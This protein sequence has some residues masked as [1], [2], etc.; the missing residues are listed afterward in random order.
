M[1]VDMLAIPDATSGLSTSSRATSSSLAGGSFAE[2]L[3][4]STNRANTGNRSPLDFR[5]EASPDAKAAV[6]TASTTNSVLKTAVAAGSVTSLV[7][8]SAKPD[9]KTQGGSANTNSHAGTTNSS[10]L[11]DERADEKA[12]ATVFPFHVQPI[13]LQPVR[14]PSIRSDVTAPQIASTLASLIVKAVPP[15]A[16][17]GSVRGATPSSSNSNLSA[18]DPTETDGTAPSSPSLIGGA[19]AAPSPANSVALPRISSASLL[20]N[21]VPA[22]GQRLIPDTFGSSAPASA[23]TSESANL[24]VNP[25]NAASYFRSNSVTAHSSESDGLSRASTISELAAASAQTSAYS[26]DNLSPDFSLTPASGDAVNPANAENAGDTDDSRSVSASESW[27]SEFQAEG[28]SEIPSLPPDLASPAAGLP[29]AT[30]SSAAA[31]VA[32]AQSTTS[33]V[34]AD[35]AQSASG[36]HANESAVAPSPGDLASSQSMASAFANAGIRAAGLFDSREFDSQEIVSPSAG[37]KIK[38]EAVSGADGAQRIPSRPDSAP[39]SSSVSA[40]RGATA[41]P[42]VTDLAAPASPDTSLTTFPGDPLAM[43]ANLSANGTEISGFAAPGSSATAT[44]AAA[45]SRVSANL[46]AKANDPSIAA[47]ASAPASLFDGQ[48]LTSSSASLAPLLAISPATSS[49][50]SLASSLATPA[51]ASTHDAAGNA[52]LVVPSPVPSGADPGTAGKSAAST[53]L[54]LAHQML[55][56]APVADVADPAIA[57]AAHLTTDPAALQMHLGIHTSAFGNVEIHTVIEQSQVGVAIHGD[58]DLARWFS[59]EVGGLETGL[60]GQHLNLTGVDFSSN[61]SGVQTA[62]GFQQGQPRQNFS[63]DSGT[64]AGAAPV[65]A[66]PGPLNESIYETESS[67]ALPVFGP[68]RRVSILA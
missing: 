68:E 4:A 28:L 58:R 17:L 45:D 10:A 40:S 55:D 16:Q 20:S 39:T 13:Q 60:K 30:P 9:S 31:S 33:S 6:T 3:A 18:A 43:G 63:Q 37:A 2:T 12:P 64:S 49:A 44:S 56:S 11:S 50:S 25:N 7:A 36:S 15:S 29:L 61:R 22:S 14:V 26:S 5:F 53:E 23:P 47:D 46:A 51:V 59:S 21:V 52:A 1:L 35:L 66:A 32:A 67:P 19:K 48:R 24:L 38:L 8:K 27:A 62:T 65:A 34:A 41:E 57:S 54:P 42:P